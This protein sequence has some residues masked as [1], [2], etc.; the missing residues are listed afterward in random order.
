LGHCAIRQGVDVFTNCSALTQS[1]H[2]ARAT[3][4][5]ERKLQ[6][7]SRIP[8]LIIDEEISQLKVTGISAM[9]DVQLCRYSENWLA[10]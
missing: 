10:R 1:L 7:L 5:Y 4:S 2:G 9:S 3:N 8:V 6:A